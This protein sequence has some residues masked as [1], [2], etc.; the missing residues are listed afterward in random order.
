MDMGVIKV[1]VYR[2]TKEVALQD[3]EPPELFLNT[4]VPVSRKVG[5]QPRSATFRLRVPATSAQG[6]PD[7]PTT[8]MQEV[9][10]ISPNEVE[11]TVRR[12]DWKRIRKSE[13]SDAKGAQGLEDYLKASRELDINDKKI[14]RLSRKAVK[15]QST[16]AEKADALRKF[17]SDFIEHKGM[18]VGFATASEVAA[19][20]R[21]DCSEHGV[22]LAALARAA[23]LPA[24]GVSG[25]VEV[26]EEA[27]DA[28]GTSAFGYHMWTQVHIDGQWVDVDAA[29]RQT[30]C[31]PTHIALA[32]MS[33]NEA[34][35]VDSISALFPL[36]GR[37]QIDVVDVQR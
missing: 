28:N 37:L 15:G 34:G 27:T 12:L 11:V 21:G 14:Q 9:R 20:R 3:A 10:R 24:R 4:L 5:T 36:L 18:D 8:G 6:I 30:D 26:P 23:G 32:I 35:L 25:I 17:V 13:A 7:L 33:L 1:N 22:L 16:P 31:D 19:N 2:T 29:L